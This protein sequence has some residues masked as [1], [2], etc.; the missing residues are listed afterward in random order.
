MDAKT[1]ERLVGQAIQELPATLRRQIVNVA[2]VVEDIA[3]DEAL[4][5]ADIDNPMDLYGLYVGIPLTARTHD[6]GLIA[7]D[8][9]SIYRRPIL[10]ACANDDEVMAFVRKTIRHEI[11][12]YFGIDDDR[13]EELD[14]Y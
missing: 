10:A 5:E 14:A 1:F 2:I 11:A 7:P 8:K 6:Y 4:D 12:H 3:D 13:L 9:I